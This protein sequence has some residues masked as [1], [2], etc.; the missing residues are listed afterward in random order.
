M[1]KIL[2]MLMAVVLF[3]STA[4]AG[5]I[6]TNTNQSASYVRLLARDASLGIDAVYFNPAGL[7][8]FNNGFYLSLSNQTVM[9]NR[10]ITN[11]NPLLNSSVYEG[12]VMAPLFPSVYAVYKYD[13]LAFSF[14]FNPVGGGGG[15]EYEN[16][17]PSFEAPVASLVPLLQPFGVTGYRN[18]IYFEGSSIFFAGQLGVSFALTDMISVFG[19]GRYVMA[20]NTYNGYLKNIEVNTPI[21]WMK[22]GDYLRAIAPTLPPAQ[23]PIVIGTASVLDSQTADAEV[24][25]KQTGNGFTPVI[26]FSLIPSERFNIG[27]KY[28][29]KTK[30]ELENETAVDGTGMFPDGEKTRSDMPAMLSVGA[31]FR[32]VDG[33]NLTGGVHYYFDKDAD[34]GRALPNEELMDNN[35]M[36]FALGAEYNITPELLFSIGYLRTQ[37]GVNELYQN[38]LSHSLNTNSVGL[39][40]MYSIT[41]NLDINLGFLYTMYEDDEISINYGEGIGSHTESYARNNMVFAIGL[42]LKIPVR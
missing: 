10:E 35:Y 23:Q 2:V 22:P 33:L 42:D 25:A 15:A 18:D 20:N 13:R 26:G 39:G 1:R 38:D 28:E 37:T 3:S 27:I 9:Q 4:L 8:S 32:P 40:G 31:G 29:F 16:G 24:D 5:G 6:M 12:K 7:T 36:E 21:G 34:Y 30:L 41:P 14:G 17:L 19:G 11:E